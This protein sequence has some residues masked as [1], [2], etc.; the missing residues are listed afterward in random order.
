MQT[1]VIICIQLESTQSDLSERETETG[2]INNADLY[3]YHRHPDIL[4]KPVSS[5]N[6]KFLL[7]YD[8]TLKDTDY[9]FVHISGL[10]QLSPEIPLCWGP[11]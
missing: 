11:V 3:R 2:V 10:F 5:E 7:T 4:E 1:F 8:L 9:Y 6:H